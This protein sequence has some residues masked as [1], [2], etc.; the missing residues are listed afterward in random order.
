MPATINSATRIKIIQIRA[1]NPE[2]PPTIDAILERLSFDCALTGERVPSRGTVGSVVQ[3]WEKL[4]DEIRY[5]DMPFEWHEIERARIPWEASRWVLDCQAAQEQ[6]LADCA[7][8]NA[9]K[10]QMERISKHN[11]ANPFTNRWATWSWRVHQARPDWDPDRVWS[12]AFLYVYAEQAQ[13][14]LPDHPSLYLKGLQGL[15]AH[16][17]DLW[18]ES[19]RNKCD[20][21]RYLYGIH[22]EIIKPLFS[23]E[24]LGTLLKSWT[25]NP[26]MGS[27]E[28]GVCVEGVAGISLWLDRW[29]QPLY[30]YFAEQETKAQEE[31]IERVN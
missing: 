3:N 9:N 8:E 24:E 22:F 13:D 18:Q 25:S 4:P 23:P 19:Q 30:G 12:I 1:S 5:R 10:G 20:G 29:R 28:K 27:H 7:V 26:S 11:S 6:W 15:L 2:H 31:V 14:V 21:I 16:R 17:P